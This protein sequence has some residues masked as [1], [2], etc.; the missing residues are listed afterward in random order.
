MSTPQPRQE[1]DRLRLARHALVRDLESTA[2]DALTDIFHVEN[3]PAGRSVLE[4]GQANSRLFIVLDGSVSVKLPKRAR[5]V[6]EVK[7]AML[8]GGDIFGEYSVFDGQPVSATVFAVQD[9]RVAWVEK[10]ALH[11]Y[12]E[13]HREAG[14]RLYEGLLKILVGRLRANDAELDVITIG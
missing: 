14:R 1:E 10:S 6:S 5:R 9:T 3:V 13:G 12:V 2:R 7:L 4:E 11:D 8:G